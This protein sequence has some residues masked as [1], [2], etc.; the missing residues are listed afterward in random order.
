MLPRIVL[1]LALAIAFVSLGLDR[2]VWPHPQK[3]K[4]NAANPKPVPASVTLTVVTKL[5]GFA[6]SLDNQPVGTT[7]DSGQLV[8]PNVKPGSHSVKVSR[9]GYADVIEIVTL[10]ADRTLTVTP[11]QISYETGLQMIHS[12]VSTGKTDQALSALQAIAAEESTRPEAYQLMGKS[13]TTKAISHRP[14]RCSVARLIAAD[15]RCSRSLTTISEARPLLTNGA[16][17]GSGLM[18]P[19]KLNL[20]RPRAGS[21]CVFCAFS[22]PYIVFLLAFFR[23]IC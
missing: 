12:Y 11:A 3:P 21:L 10:N 17:G 1:S 2:D 20:N 6:V 13:T 18:K 4:L 16:T 8:I 9:E 23:R 14:E 22:W 7:D 15:K 19:V 5:P